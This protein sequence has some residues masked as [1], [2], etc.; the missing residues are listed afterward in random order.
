MHSTHLSVSFCS[1][2]LHS[3]NV[4]AALGDICT[5]RYFCLLLFALI[6]PEIILGVCLPNTVLGF[7]TDASSSS[8]VFLLPFFCLRRILFL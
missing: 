8:Y 2:V 5:A 6:D 7:A 3:L 4:P 1:G